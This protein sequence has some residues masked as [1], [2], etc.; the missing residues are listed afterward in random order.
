MSMESDLVTL[1]KS[2]LPNLS[3]RCRRKVQVNVVHHGRGLAA[4]RFAMSKDRRL[5]DLQHSYADQRLERDAARSTNPDP[6]DRGCA[7]RV[8]V[9]SPKRRV[10]DY[11]Q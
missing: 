7:L 1:L 4:N 5:T 9:F 8:G 2:H 6:A 10:V 3:G 11:R